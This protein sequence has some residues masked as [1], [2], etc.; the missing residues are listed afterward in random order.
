MTSAMFATFKEREREKKKLSGNLLQD[1]RQRYGS[2]PIRIRVKPNPGWPH[3]DLLFIAN[4]DVKKVQ[5][6]I[7]SRFFFFR[8][9]VPV[10]QTYFKTLRA[11]AFF[12]KWLAKESLGLP[13]NCFQSSNSTFS[14]KDTPL[15]SSERYNSIIVLLGFKALTYL[16]G[17]E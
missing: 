7:I 2:C 13:F 17:K 14:T 11:E 9:K 4:A 15:E 5:P 6:L 16:S 8:G 10:E 12:I 3:G 1:A